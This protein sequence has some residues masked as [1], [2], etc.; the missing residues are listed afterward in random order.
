MTLDKERREIIE[1]QSSFFDAWT[2]IFTVESSIKR[3]HK[4]FWSGFYLSIVFCFEHL[5]H[6]HELRV[7]SASVRIWMESF[8][9][10]RA[11]LA[12][13]CE[14]TDIVA[15]GRG[16]S[17]SLLLTSLQQV[18]NLFVLKIL[19]RESRFSCEFFWVW[20]AILW[21]SF[22]YWRQRSLHIFLLLIAIQMND[23]ILIYGPLILVFLIMLAIE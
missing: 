5:D 17:V 2:N 13:D 16:W 15:V 10:W 18:L 11:N 7:A 9:V 21:L 8:M 3:I 19:L 12:A 1:G 20:R 6:I 23:A 14:L 22:S 4:I